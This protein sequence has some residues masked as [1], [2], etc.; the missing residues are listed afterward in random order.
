M[1]F[2]KESVKKI[3]GLII[4]TAIV[5]LC[6]WEY[7]KVF[8][9]LAFVFHILFPFILGGAIAFVLNVPMNF[10]E[11]HLFGSDK[12]RK[13]KVLSKMARPVSMLIVLLLVF[14][15][16][17]IVMF[18][19]IPQLGRTFANLGES[20]QAFI[21]RV[22]TRAA[23]LFHNNKEVMKWVNDLEFDW[24]KVMD[25]GI[26]F[27][28]SGAGSVLDSTITAAKSIVSGIA[29]FFIAFVFACYV[30][31]QKE[32]LNIQAKKVLFAFVRR[33]RAEAALEVF[34]LTYSTFSSFLTGQC[35]E[36]VILGGMFVVSMA[37][38]RL[39]Y[40]LL[41]GIVIAFT[42][43]IP[44]FGAFIGCAVGAFL[45]FMVDPV[46]ALVFVALFLV[47]QQIEGNLIYPHVVGN[48]VGLPSIWVLAAVSIGGSLM[49]IVGM[50]IFIP[51]VSVV[52]ALFRE[53]VYLKLR[54]KRVEPGSIK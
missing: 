25:A 42:A 39:P 15:V 47:L 19:L 44:I 33:G 37:L 3:R 17:G 8:D 32:K 53:I 35:V 11:R 49:G 34:S 38:F 30:L 2:S 6:L 4:F 5:V 20:I 43:L 27:F 41:V 22:Q 23:D 48:S 54:Q 7:N 26:E 14:S 1:E 52:Y 51:V 16:I 29:T 18:I 21:P 12:V 13:S 9:I 46:K 28:R 50:L 10:V 31:L 40:A 36:A 24:N 45:I